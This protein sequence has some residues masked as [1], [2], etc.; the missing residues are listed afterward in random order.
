MG[1]IAA[2]SKKDSLAGVYQKPSIGRE[3]SFYT[4]HPLLSTSLLLLDSLSSMN[5]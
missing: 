4:S 2:M 3:K 5:I 1:F